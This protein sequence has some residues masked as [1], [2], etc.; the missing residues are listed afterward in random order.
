MVGTPSTFALILKFP[1]IFM[2]DLMFYGTPK[3]K[4]KYVFTQSSIDGC[5]QRISVVISPLSSLRFSSFLLQP[6]SSASKAIYIALITWNRSNFFCRLSSR[7]WVY[8][9]RVRDEWWWQESGSTSDPKIRNWRFEELQVCV[10]FH[11]LWQKCCQVAREA[12]SQVG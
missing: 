5:R 3:K 1:A 11:L 7:L 4:K 6:A 8:F 12:V 10:E 2:S 9:E